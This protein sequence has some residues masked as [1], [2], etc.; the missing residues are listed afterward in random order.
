MMR[1]SLGGGSPAF[2]SSCASSLPRRG[3]S[4][5]NSGIAS[6]GA[7]TASTSGMNGCGA[8]HVLTQHP[9]EQLRGWSFWSCP[10]PLSAQQASAQHE[11]AARS[12]PSIAWA[13]MRFSQ[14]QSDIHAAKAK[15][16]SRCSV[17][18]KDTVLGIVAF[19]DRRC[20]RRRSIAAKRRIT[21]RSAADAT[22]DIRRRAC[23]WSRR[24]AASTWRLPPRATC[25]GRR[26]WTAVR[27]R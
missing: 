8:W 9:S 23:L 10:P 22:R 11:G 21:P 4:C 2:R 14:Q 1:A 18:E 12:S 19:P 26:R 25:S 17:R 20:K 13:R 15:V 3:C 7:P 16:S 24:P 27:M 5:L 6:I